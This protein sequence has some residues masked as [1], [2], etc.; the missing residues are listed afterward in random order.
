MPDCHDMLELQADA[1]AV[2][3]ALEWLETIA[4][5]QGWPPRMTFG[6]TLC[7]DEALTNIVSYA[8]SPTTDEVRPAITTSCRITADTVA[9]TLCDNGRPYDPTAGDPPP[10]VACLDEAQPGGHGVR[11]MRHYL[12]ELSYQRQAGWNCLTMV[13]RLS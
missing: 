9:L 8:F 4:D 5:R 11:L 7:L 10:L 13:M 6:L 12:N 1:Q 2:P 3:Q